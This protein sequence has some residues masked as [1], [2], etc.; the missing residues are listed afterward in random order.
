MALVYF[1]LAF[2]L[3]TGRAFGHCQ[4]CGKSQDFSGPTPDVVLK[5]KYGFKLSE[6]LML[7]AKEMGV[8]NL[9]IGLKYSKISPL[10]G[11]RK[12]GVG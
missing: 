10:L 7:F 5:Q 11:K 12:T 8:C 6:K 4:V 2:M 3:N 1:W 9:V